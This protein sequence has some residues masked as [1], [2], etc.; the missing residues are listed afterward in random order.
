MIN[1]KKIKDE[2]EDVAYFL[3]KGDKKSLNIADMIYNSI[4]TRCFI[5]MIQSG[6]KS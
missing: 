3:N 1:Y 5:R 6:N 4:K 2:L